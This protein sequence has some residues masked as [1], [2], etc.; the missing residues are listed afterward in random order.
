M[1][2]LNRATEPIAL[3]DVGVSAP[4][5]MAAPK[6]KAP[7]TNAAKTAAVAGKAKTAA[8]KRLADNPPSPEKEAAATKSATELG[9]RDRRLANVMSQALGG[10]STAGAA[11]EA[12]LSMAERVAGAVDGVGPSAGA[13]AAASQPKRKGTPKVIVNGVD[14]LARLN[15]KGIAARAFS[16]ALTLRLGASATLADPAFSSGAARL[17]NDGAPSGDLR[18]GGSASP[19]RP[20]PARGSAASL[21][22]AARLGFWGP[23]VPA[24]AVA[25]ASRPMLVSFADAC[26]SGGDGVAVLAGA[27]SDAI[28]ANARRR[29]VAGEGAA[30]IAGAGVPSLCTV[31]MAAARYTCVRCLGFHGTVCSVECLAT[32]RSTR[33]LKHVV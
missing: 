2:R 13:E 18:G 32:H 31:C 16:D 29:F 24:A 19:P 22:E 26:G 25:P 23:L 14:V 30:P 7:P 1:P 6:K 3:H 20:R 12:S 27:A 15:A 28:V 4:L 21:K 33:C 9:V 10:G 8:S 17:A 5:G 11:L